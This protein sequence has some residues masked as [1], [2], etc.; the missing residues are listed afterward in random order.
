MITTWFTLIISCL[1]LSWICGWCKR[2]SMA[3]CKVVAT[4]SEPAINKSR[5][6]TNRFL[7]EDRKSWGMLK[8]RVFKR[9]NS[10]NCYKW[11]NSTLEKT[12][13]QIDLYLRI[14][15]HSFLQK[16]YIMTMLWIP[17]AWRMF[18]LC[19]FFLI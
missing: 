19:V 4:D 18:K 5:I 10:L 13:S 1:H 2:Y 14:E 6:V 7:S 9:C 16:L 11:Y 15:S 12:K 17:L 3:H 8:F